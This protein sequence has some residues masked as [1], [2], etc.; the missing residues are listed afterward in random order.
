MRG[1][2]LLKILGDGG[3]AIKEIRVGARYRGYIDPAIGADRLSSKI[4][5]DPRVTD[6]WAEEWFE[7]PFY[8][9]VKRV[10][11]FEVEDPHAL[12]E[13]YSRVERLGLGVRANTYPGVVQATLHRLGIPLC[14]RLR[15]DLAVSEDLDDPLYE[16]P[17]IRWAWLKLL[18]WYGE[19][20][21]PRSRIEGFEIETPHG[22][23]RGS[24]D[25]LI[26]S[27]E[28]LEPHVILYSGPFEGLVRGMANAVGA[29]PVYMATVP[30]GLHGAVEW[31][32]LSYTPLRMI[33]RYS[34]G[35]VLTSIEALEALSRK[36]MIPHR[37]RGYAEPPRRADQLPRFDRGGYI[38]KPEPGVYFGVFQVDFSSLYPSIISRYNISPETVNDP[39]CS[40][41][42]DAPEVGHR[43]C[44][45]RRGLV[46]DVM[47]RLVSRRQAIKDAMGRG[48]GLS[49]EILDDRQSALKWILVA[50]FGYLG[51]R[52]ARFGRIDSYEC[53]T[54][55]ARETA[56]K[57][58]EAVHAV[59]YRVIHYIVDSVFIEAGTTD[60]QEAERV[61][62]EVGNATG[63][64]AKVEAIYRWLVIPPTVEGHGASNR[65][66]GKL[67]DGSI[68]VKG[69]DPVRAD[70]PPVIKR[71]W[72]EALEILSG[73]DTP[74]ELRSKALEALEKLGAAVEE[75]ALGSIAKEDLVI[76]RS[77]GGEIAQVIRHRKFYEAYAPRGYSPGYYIRR[78]ENLKRILRYIV[79]KL[80]PVSE[81]PNTEHRAGRT[82]I[83]P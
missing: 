12:G 5:E 37:P 26:E 41:Y 67:L 57:A 68:K 2:I 13:I 61:A 62:R 3:G 66:F 74:G 48:E 10:T 78:L 22:T 77:I 82:A 81:K 49:P 56:W 36:Y 27:L 72:M 40:S 23:T 14:T 6:S 35:R 46:A 16:P 17:P 4:L 47:S 1:G 30:I 79:E 76:T 38:M 9:S 20:L 7:P 31:C 18:S 24:L 51:Y 69:V 39:M 52:N 15:E 45:D 29:V 59:G 11:V 58:I 42:L 21:S 50:S 34:I 8:R 70:T 43:I 75:I 65:Y 28:D 71:I 83:S 44:I 19:A 64:R 55:Y 25:R 60:P 73:A 53:V 80:E 54:A 33:G 32:R 63:F